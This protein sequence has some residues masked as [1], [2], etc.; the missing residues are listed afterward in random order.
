MHRDLALIKVPKELK[1][2]L[3]LIHSYQL[4]KILARRNDA[5]GSARLLIR[6]A[7]NASKFTSHIVSVLTSV[8]LQCYAVEFHKSALQYGT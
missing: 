8:V 5:V 4:A 3:M 6:V 1:D 2:R 7:A